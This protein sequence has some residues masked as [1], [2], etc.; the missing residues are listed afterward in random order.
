MFGSIFARRTTPLSPELGARQ[1][2]LFLGLC[3][4]YLVQLRGLPQSAQTGQ[5]GVAEVEQRP[6]RRD[7]RGVPGVLAGIGHCHGHLAGPEQPHRVTLPPEHDAAELD[8]LREQGLPGG[9]VL[10]R[11][12]GNGVFAFVASV[13]AGIS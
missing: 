8:L 11:T 1:R 10:G 3:A 6:E 13:A 2:P 12:P 7:V 4:R 9:A 5:G